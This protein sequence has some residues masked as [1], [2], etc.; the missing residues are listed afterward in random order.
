MRLRPPRIM[1][2]PRFWPLSALNGARP[3][4]AAMALEERAPS[5]G[6]RGEQ[7]GGG[8][9][10]DAGDGAQPPVRYRRG[11][12]WRRSAGGSC[13][14]AR[15]PAR[16]ASCR[17]ILSNSRIYRRQLLLQFT[18]QHRIGRGRYA[19]RNGSIVGTLNEVRPVA[20]HGQDKLNTF[21]ILCRN[22]AREE[23]TE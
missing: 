23:H 13:G 22:R 16:R 10:T 12:R 5:S 4:K 2:L 7:G 8:D 18:D 20:F 9:R 19:E 6:A 3:A 15:G 1:R 14:R 11:W 21:A 17:S